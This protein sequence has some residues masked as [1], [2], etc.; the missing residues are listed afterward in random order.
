MYACICFRKVLF[1]YMNISID[2]Y[3]SYRAIECLRTAG[4]VDAELRESTG[5]VP[6]A[7]AA[8]QRRVARL[9]RVQRG[10][11][12]RREVQA[13]Q[14][15]QRAARVHQHRAVRSAAL[16]VRRRKHTG[17]KHRSGGRV[18]RLV[19]LSVFASNLEFRLINY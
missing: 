3:S 7:A 19:T 6:R 5:Q 18:R 17:H 8:A 13:G 10:R 16:L 14:I 9:I 1:V 12:R 2:C 4:A 15:R 11:Q